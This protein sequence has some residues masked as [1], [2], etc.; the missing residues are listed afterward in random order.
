MNLILRLIL[1]FLW[2]TISV[3]KGWLMYEEEK[4]KKNADYKMCKFAKSKFMKN[5]MNIKHHLHEEED[6]ELIAAY[7]KSLEE[8]EK[9]RSAW[10]KKYKIEEVITIILLSIIMFSVLVD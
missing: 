6:K 7:K 2:L 1:L 5:I 8:H 3:L 10:I 4:A 9:R